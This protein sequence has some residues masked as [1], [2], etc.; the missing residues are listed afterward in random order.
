MQLAVEEKLESL[1]EESTT[2]SDAEV[3]ESVRVGKTQDLGILVDRYHRYAENCALQ[4]AYTHHLTTEDAQDAV[5]NACVKLLNK[6]PSIEQSFP[7]YFD[8]TVI[9]ELRNQRVTQRAWGQKPP[10]RIDIPG[11]NGERFEIKDYRKPPQKKDERIPAMWDA[12]S[13]LSDDYKMPLY[14]QYVADM[15]LNQIAQELELPEGT[16]K[17]R[18]SVAKDRLRELLGVPSQ[19]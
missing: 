16:V 9:N 4:Y 3:W 2:P 10:L 8:T 18:I 5:Q 12:V 6:K 1:D 13:T 17:R 19:K 14:Q 7:K 15:P 11:L